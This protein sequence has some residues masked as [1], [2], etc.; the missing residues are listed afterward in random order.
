M[1]DRRCAHCQRSISLF[2]GK[3]KYCSDACRQAA[4]RARKHA[5][6]KRVYIKRHKDKRCLFCGDSFNAVRFD[7]RCCSNRCAKGLYYRRRRTVHK[8]PCLWCGKPFE[9][10]RSRHVY[11]CDEC[12]KASQA[13]ARDEAK[14]AS[15]SD[16]RCVGCGEAIN[17]MLRSDA[18]FCSGRCSTHHLRRGVSRKRPPIEGRVCKECGGAID[19]AARSDAVYCSR[20]CGG[21]HRKRSPE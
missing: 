11:C 13:Q 8:D 6:A 10:T 21:R 12:W 18:K 4:Y 2:H 15:R 9:R 17:P 20:A 5:N 14:I 1:S 19:P 7:A 3:S 16:R